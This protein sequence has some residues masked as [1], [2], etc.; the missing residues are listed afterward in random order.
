K[1]P[2]QANPSPCGTR[3]LLWRNTSLNGTATPIFKGKNKVLG[4]S[5]TWNF[6]QRIKRRDEICK[7]VLTDSKGLSVNQVTEPYGQEYPLC[8]G[9]A[10]A[11]V[12]AW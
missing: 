12:S 2:K 7:L 6:T 4:V 1:E 3:G 5:I 11:A 8:K 10:P 9:M